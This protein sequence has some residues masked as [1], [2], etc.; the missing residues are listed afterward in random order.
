LDFLLRLL[1][2][3]V[4]I[5]DMSPVL[6]LLKLVKIDPYD[7]FYLLLGYLFLLPHRILGVEYQWSGIQV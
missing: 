6:L 2:E 7:S 5:L 3:Y 1:Y 4:S